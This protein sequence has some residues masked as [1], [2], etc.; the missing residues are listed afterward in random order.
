MGA[1]PLEARLPLSGT[2]VGILSDDEVIQWSVRGR[3]DPFGL[4]GAV[5][6]VSTP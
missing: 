1:Q 3:P 4:G 2:S 6:A 5:S